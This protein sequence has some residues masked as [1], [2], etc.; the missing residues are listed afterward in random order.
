MLYLF[1]PKVV[2]LWRGSALVSSQIQ[3]VFMRQLLSGL[4]MLCLTTFLL[5]CAPT[6]PAS[7]STTPASPTNSVVQISTVATSE[8]TA[9]FTP[10][11]SAP[12]SS[13]D[14]SILQSP[15]VN[16]DQTV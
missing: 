5:A 7:F 6:N 15:V 11:S 1:S 12:T 4:V 8:G 9:T 14:P 2:A 3:G 16:T 10:Q 13:T